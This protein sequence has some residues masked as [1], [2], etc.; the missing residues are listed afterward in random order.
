MLDETVLGE[1]S[2]YIEIPL[3]KFGIEKKLCTYMYVSIYLLRTSST[4]LEYFVLTK[5]LFLLTS[6]FVVFQNF[7]KNKIKI[8]LVHECCN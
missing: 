8:V 7:E 3:M 4:T 2:L 6:R 5:K 1:E